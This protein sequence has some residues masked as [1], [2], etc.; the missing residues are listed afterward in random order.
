MPTIPWARLWKDIQIEC[1]RRTD[2]AAKKK[3]ATT[4]HRT[5][6]TPF[7]NDK[8]ETGTS[9]KTN[10]C[11]EQKKRINMDK[12]TTS[13]MYRENENTKWRNKRE[14]ARERERD[15]E[16]KN[17]QTTIQS[18]YGNSMGICQRSLNKT[19]IKWSNLCP[20]KLV[21]EH[22]YQQHIDIRQH[23]D[24]R[25]VQVS[26][27]N[28]PI[29]ALIQKKYPAK[30]GTNHKHKHI[31][32]KIRMKFKSNI[33]SIQYERGACCGFWFKWRCCCGPKLSYRFQWW[34]HQLWSTKALTTESI[35]SEQSS[36][37]T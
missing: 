36:N 32:H 9:N 6:N 21:R 24:D 12:T 8:I 14:I 26:A 27:L 2:S 16:K 19:H 13:H 23:D 3:T 4:S 20:W 29:N 15:K 31:S 5:Q 35:A 7:T 25:L 37:R 30:I 18:E 22:H 1:A 28:C 10:E 11:K 33:H 17:E 34:F